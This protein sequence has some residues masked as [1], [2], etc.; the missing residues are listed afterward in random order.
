MS[1]ITYIYASICV[2]FV[3][4]TCIQR[5]TWRWNVVRPAL[6][7]LFL[8]RPLAS[9]NTLHSCS[10]LFYTYLY[11][12]CICTHIFCT[13]MQDPPQNARVVVT[14]ATR[15]SD[16]LSA[17]VP[18]PITERSSSWSFVYP[19]ISWVHRPMYVCMY[20]CKDTHLYI[21]IIIYVYFSVKNVRTVPHN[22]L[23]F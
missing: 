4:Y 19:S 21:S 1:P 3:A 16:F 6:T 20:V 2:I 13:I 10:S 9:G 5:D 15:S 12:H 22:I 17:F 23:I 7:L 18:F 11:T 8:Y 14:T